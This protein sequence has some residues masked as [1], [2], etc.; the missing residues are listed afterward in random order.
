MCVCVMIHL[1]LFHAALTGSRFSL[2]ESVLN[3]GENKVVVQATGASGE[4]A[5]AEYS[6]FRNTATLSSSP[7][8]TYLA[9]ENEH[10][11]NLK[12]S[13]EDL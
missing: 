1:I 10:I 13:G 7:I 8:G 12:G 11:L 9:L 2:S 6:V 4:R 3:E 5:D